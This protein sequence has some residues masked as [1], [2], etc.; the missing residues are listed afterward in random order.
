MFIGQFDGG[1]A[2]GRGGWF[3]ATGRIIGDFVEDV[4]EGRVT[5]WGQGGERLEGEYR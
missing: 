3:G 5:W 2:H 1:R 4:A